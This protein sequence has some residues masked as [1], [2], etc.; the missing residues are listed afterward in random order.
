[1]IA[2][3]IHYMLIEMTNLVSLITFD[4]KRRSTSLDRW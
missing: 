1:M 4:E 3:S 2:A